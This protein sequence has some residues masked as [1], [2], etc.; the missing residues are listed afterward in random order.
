MTAFRY[1][2]FRLFWCGAL[3]SNTG[4]WVQNVT[5]PFVFW[6]LTGSALWVGAAAF[7]QFIPVV[8]MGPIAGS[9]ADRKPRR[10]VLL[11]SQS[12]MAV[13]ALALWITWIAGVRSPWVLLVLVGASGLV[14]GL[15]IASWQAF[16]SELVPRD[17]LPN[18][19]T[20]NSAQFNAARAFGPALGG[21]VLATLGVSWSFLIN[22][23]SFA[24]VLTAVGLIR[25]PKLIA[26]D[27]P[28][29]PIV[30]EFA[31]TVR[32]L[33]ARRGI[34][35]CVLVVIALAG[36]GSPVFQLTVVFA[37]EV[38]GVGRV[39]FGALGAAL[40]LGAVLAAPLV[41]G[42]GS[43]V[44]RSRLV[45]GA[46]TLY[47]AAVAAFG[48][49][50]SYWFGLAALLVAGGAYLAIASTLN[51]TIQ[52]LVDESMRGKVLAAYL[53][54]MTVAL[55]VG[56]LAQGAA[57]DVVGPRLVVATAGA[58]LVA[59]AAWLRLGSGL[60]PHMDGDDARPAIVEP[61]PEPA[62]RVAP[63]PATG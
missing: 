29:Q 37:D 39:A 19:V 46:L 59:V 61:E 8:V 45:F 54:A 6:Q 33:V 48:L 31:S 3:V 22:A 41:A 62:P 35:A 57:V 11:A 23:L 40:G 15:M 34:L 55:P 24:A 10:S 32:Y 30:R 4:T 12:A 53:M 2:N 38:F 1:R 44:P 50:P 47:G 26:H 25:V 17:I 18:A 60:L 56:A 36:L 28:V 58:G 20:L 9:L 14:A 43:H 16:V 42:W 7:A 13:V 49:A 63:R 51:T 5:V 21:L 52:L 27:G